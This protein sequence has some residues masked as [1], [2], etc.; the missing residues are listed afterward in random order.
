M[1]DVGRADSITLKS[2]DELTAHR[3]EDWAPAA[4]DLA[5]YTGRFFS[6][7]LE[8]FYTVELGEDGLLI[9]HRRL[10]DIELTPK[11]EDSFNATFPITE[12]EFIRGGNGDV[13]GMMVSNI[14]TRNV[15]F[16]RQQ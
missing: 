16:D 7:E 14:R 6:V 8:T 9:K 1:A 3:L 4:S 13:T 11:V 5:I 10:E 15:R 2:N 12:V